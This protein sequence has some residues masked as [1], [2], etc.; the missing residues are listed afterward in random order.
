MRMSALADELQIARRSATSLVDALE[1]RR[2]VTRRHDPSDRRAV[3]VV[4]TAAGTRL[5]A[6]ARARHR[7]STIGLLGPLSATELRTLRSLL[8]RIVG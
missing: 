1:A 3:T 6:E 8:G 4:V 7:R 5:I 2:L